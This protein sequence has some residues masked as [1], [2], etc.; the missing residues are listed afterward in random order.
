MRDIML[1]CAVL[2]NML[3]RHQGG[4]ER[5]PTPPDDIQP[6]QSDQGEQGQ[7]AKFKNASREAKH[8]R[9]LLKDYFNNL[10]ALAGKKDRIYEV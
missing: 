1:T 6:P 8:Q 3:R 9:D 2:H 5:P 4:V 10:G 7:N